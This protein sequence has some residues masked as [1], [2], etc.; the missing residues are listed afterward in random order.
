MKRNL[1]KIAVPLLLVAVCIISVGYQSM[2]AD[3]EKQQAQAVIAEMNRCRQNPKD[4][5]ETALKKRLECFVDETVYLDANGN[6]I[7]T[8]EGRRR[9]LEAIS[10]LRGMQPVD[11]LAYD[12]ELTNAARFHCSDIGP[13]GLT[14][15]NS[16]DGT[17]MTDRLKRYVKDRMSW[18]ENIE[19]GSS[20]AEDIVVNLVI[21]DG[22]PSR[23]HLRNIMESSYHRAGAAIGPHQQYRFMC[24]IDFSD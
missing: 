8:S 23:G 21:D 15:H 17:S 7:V 10:E 9:V 24:V 18:G 16:S 4:Y 13:S 22:V 19:F 5:A 12:E 2:P 14:G 3:D 11:P 6:R 20:N 1:I